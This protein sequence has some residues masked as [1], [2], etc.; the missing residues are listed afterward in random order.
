MRDLGIDVLENR[1]Q[2]ISPHLLELLL[3]DQTKTYHAPNGKAQYI[4]WANSDYEELGPNFSYSAPI[5]PELITG[6]NGSIIRPRI[7][8]AKDEQSNRS[9]NMAEVYT[10]AWLCN[11]QNN[12]IDEQWFGRPD[13]FNQTERAAMTWKSNPDKITFPQDKTWQ[14]Y[15]K[16][17]RLE[18]TCGEAPYLVSRYDMTT[19]QYIQV[20][21]RIGLL[22]RKL[23]VISENTR[24]KATWLK[25]AKVAFQSVY[26]YEWQGDSLLLARENMLLTFS[27]FYQ[28]RWGEAPELSAIIE[29]ATIISWNLWQMDALRGVIPESCHEEITYSNSLFGLEEITSPC[30]GCSCEKLLNHQHTGMYCLIKDWTECDKKS[31]NLGQIKRFVDLF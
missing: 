18:V 6:D 8:K 21:D 12:L 25:W 29:I 13:V 4:F 20:N 27:E 28:E 23:R 31:G 22:D 5:S 30:P 17:I 9:R 10:P 19:G 26:G 16:S 14:D 15:V 24:T 1:L 11:K 2:S 7:L 3:I